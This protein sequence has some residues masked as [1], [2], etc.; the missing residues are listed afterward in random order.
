M[1]ASILDHPV[2]DHSVRAWFHHLKAGRITRAPTLTL[3]IRFDSVPSSPTVTEGIPGSKWR[4]L[5]S[6]SWY[7]TLPSESALADLGGL[8]Q[9]PGVASI[10]GPSFSLAQV[11]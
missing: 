9:I 2:I 10:S 1:T 11:G 8:I 7:V 6:R 5:T 4:Q 3:V